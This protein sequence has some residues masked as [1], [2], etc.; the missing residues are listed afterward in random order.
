MVLPLVITLH[1]LYIHEK[2]ILPKVSPN[3]P[4]LTAGLI[5]SRLKY[6]GILSI[7]MPDA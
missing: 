6:P 1:Q 5:A 7:K 3:M 4:I 2:S